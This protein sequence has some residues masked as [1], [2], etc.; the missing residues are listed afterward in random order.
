MLHTECVPTVWDCA[1]CQERL[2]QQAL[3]VTELLFN[4]VHIHFNVF[5]NTLMYFTVVPV[6]I[7]N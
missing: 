6:N 1:S 5:L 2:G 7:S 4:N 3:G